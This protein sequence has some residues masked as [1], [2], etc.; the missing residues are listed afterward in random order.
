V[1]SGAAQDYLLSYLPI[2]VP[3]VTPRQDADFWNASAELTWKHGFSTFTVLPAFRHVDYDNLSH[4]GFVVG[5]RATSNQS[6]LELRW[7]GD[8]ERANWVTGLY[9]FRELEA[10]KTRILA[11]PLIQDIDIYFRPDTRSYAAFG[12]ATINVT[13]TLRAIAGARYTSDERSMDGRT[14]DYS[15]GF[16]RPFSGSKTFTKTTGKVGLEY[17]LAPKNMLY[18]TVS[19]GFKSGGINQEVAPNVFLPE[20]LTSYEIGSRNRFFDDR[21][22]INAEVYYWKYRDRQ[23]TTITLDNSFFVNLIVENAGQATI[24]GANIDIVAKPWRNG[25]FHGFI[26]YNRARYDSYVYTT[27]DTAYGVPFFDP[28]STGCKVGDATP[29]ELPG[30]TFRSIDCSGFP[31]PRSPEWTGTLGYTHEVTFGNG[32]QLTLDATGQFASSRYLWQNFIAVTRAKPYTTV[33]LSGTYALPGGH[34]SASVFARNVTNETVYQGG[35]VN[36]YIAT[37]FAAT[38]NPPRTFGARLSYSF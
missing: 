25:S 11:S 14:Q 29:G 38:I 36:P 9:Y 10:A 12:Q 6:S 3:S 33:D 19:T 27:V 16:A 2:I 8:V 28:R 17:D 22:Q 34:W 35:F 30:S 13:P 32:G 15:L 1:L 4:S 5:Q 21:L 20:R 23:E 26:E 18:A 24:K 31:L 7:A 37:L